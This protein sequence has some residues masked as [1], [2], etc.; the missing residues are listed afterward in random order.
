MRTP[1]ATPAI[2][3]ACPETDITVTDGYSLTAERRAISAGLDGLRSPGAEPLS[4]ADQVNLA[5]AAGYAVVASSGV[6]TRRAASPSMGLIGRS[7][8]LSLEFG[9]SRAAWGGPFA[10]GV[11]ACR[12]NGLLSHGH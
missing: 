4:R 10:C 2:R 7:R 1:N 9:G 3:L 6:T 11:P 12:R 5:K 8:W